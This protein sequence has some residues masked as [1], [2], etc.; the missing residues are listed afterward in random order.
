LLLRPTPSKPNRKIHDRT[1]KRKQRPDGPG[2]VEIET[3]DSEK[4]LI[5]CPAIIGDGV[6]LILD[7]RVDLDLRIH[8]QRLRTQ[9]RGSEEQPLRKRAGNVS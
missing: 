3:K 7:I 1:A 6:K 8:L 4:Y 5:D 2:Q 9:I